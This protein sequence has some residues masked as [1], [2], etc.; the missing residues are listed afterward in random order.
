M[1]ARAKNF[2]SV[3][4]PHRGTKRRRC[5]TVRIHAGCRTALW[6][7]VRRVLCPLLVEAYLVYELQKAPYNHM[8]PIE[9]GRG[10]PGS[11]PS[12]PSRI[13]PRI[14]ADPTRGDEALALTRITA[15]GKDGNHG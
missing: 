12:R 2:N 1:P 5:V 4:R 8:L 10:S 15:R 6:R 11:K 9:W 3:R 13:Y 7:V 14:L